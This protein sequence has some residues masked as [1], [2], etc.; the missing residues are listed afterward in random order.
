MD[1]DDDYEY[2]NEDDVFVP[3]VNV[4]DRVGRGGLATYSLK[5]AK[6]P[7]RNLK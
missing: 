6:N 7:S 3:E 4:R 5:G 1:E 2:A